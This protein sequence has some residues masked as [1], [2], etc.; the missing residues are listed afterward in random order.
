[1]NLVSNDIINHVSL[2]LS[3]NENLV[4]SSVTKQDWNIDREKHKKNIIY[5]WVMPILIAN[6]NKNF[7]IIIT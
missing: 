3:D 2:F 4:L 5:R 6:K 7:A 1:M